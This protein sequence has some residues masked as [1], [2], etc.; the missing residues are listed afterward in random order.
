[1]RKARTIP[2]IKSSIPLL[3]K[4]S[5]FNPAKKIWDISAR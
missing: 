1:M 5:N 2:E 4:C 3:V